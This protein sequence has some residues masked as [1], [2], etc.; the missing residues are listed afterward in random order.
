MSTDTTPRRGAA[1]RVTGVIWGAIVTAVGGF[2]IAAL[3]G[4]DIDIELV[5]I[6]ALAALGAWLLF[7]A[8]GVALRD[9]PGR[10]SGGGY[11][12]APPAS[13]SAPEH[14]ARRDS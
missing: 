4:Y 5:A 2:L 6:V 7:S 3:S 12:A 9:R 1:E 8:I 14:E 10:G 11:A 13:S